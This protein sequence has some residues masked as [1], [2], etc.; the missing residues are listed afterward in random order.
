MN[1]VYIHG[2][3]AT[4]DSFNFIRSKLSGYNDI[5]LDFAFSAI[6]VFIKRRRRA[7]NSLPNVRLQPLDNASNSFSTKANAGK[8]RDLPGAHTLSEVEPKY[9]PVPLLVGPGQAD[10]QVLVDLIQQD[11]ESDFLLAALDIPSCF[12]VDVGG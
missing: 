9:H 3:H 8:R 5:L 7:E 12:R 10:F 4:A 2:N 11:P 1:L 6:V